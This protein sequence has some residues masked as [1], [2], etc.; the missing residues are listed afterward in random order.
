M[1]KK[2]YALSPLS[3][4]G[5][6]G[7]WGRDSGIL[8]R[9]LQG[10]GY[11]SKVLMPPP[12]RKETEPDIQRATM[13]ELTSV[14]WWR[15][16][17]LEGVIVAGWGR[18][19][20]TPI[21]RAIYKSGT[22]CVLSIDGAGIYF[23]LLERASVVKSH[24]QMERWTGDPFLV[25]CGKAAGHLLRN[26]AA[27]LI[28]NSYLKYR[29]LRFSDLV[30]C[31]SPASAEGHKELC[32]LFGGRSH[33]IHI[34]QIGCPVSAFFQWNPSV[35]KER[36]I[37]AIARWDDS[38]QKR[39]LLLMKVIEKLALKD[40]E[41][42]VDIF[43]KP[44]PALEAWHRSLEPSTQCRVV[45]HGVQPREVMLPVAIRAQ[46]HFSSASYESGP[47]VLFEMLRCGVSSVFLDSR[48]L[49]GPRWVGE[50]GH[51][52]LVPRD[53]VDAYIETLELA[54][55]KWEEGAYC[56]EQISNYWMERTDPL[57][58]VRKM[59]DLGLTNQRKRLALK[60][61]KTA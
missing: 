13:E 44:T 32:T 48:A 33:G 50:C 28:R 27:T 2:W 6:G 58:L 47:L 42:E 22:C 24:W 59:V 49:P 43:G 52:D 60:K 31:Q 11:E 19:R 45:L 26:G 20:D 10:L 21:V 35:P 5:E 29:H 51:V 7:F 30:L 39:P 3:F 61:L 34:E 57:V 55:K 18:H 1:K 9:A 4:A 37:I 12:A 54:L 14:E 36:R 8:C 23:P 40:R 41:V 38:R 56:P 25:Q 46:V 17:G 15:Q 53:T 16:L